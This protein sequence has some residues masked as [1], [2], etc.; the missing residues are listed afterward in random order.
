MVEKATYGPGCT[1]CTI[2][3]PCKANSARSYV[4]NS[5]AER[6]ALYSESVKDPAVF[7]SRIAAD[8]FY[9]EKLWPADKPVLEY[10]YHR[11]RGKVFV[12]WFDG[13]IT[14][15]C[16]NAL[17]RHLPQHKSRVCYYWEGNAEG[18][19]STVTYGEMHEAVLQLAAVLRHQYGIR[20]GHVV[21]LYLPMVP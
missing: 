9:W 16:Y 7:W 15:M 12:R 3:E 4:G 2:V 13:A 21:T 20:K 1:R 17:D 11:S 19:S 14:N 8:N 18:E 6:Q 5:L 10:N